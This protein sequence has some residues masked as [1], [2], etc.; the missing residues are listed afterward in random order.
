MGRAEG[1]GDGDGGGGASDDALAATLASD[2]AVPGAAALATTIASDDAAVETPASGLAATVAASASSAPV[3]P[4][5]EV[6]PMAPG[7]YLRTEADAEI[8]RGAIGRV[9]RYLDVHLGRE[10]AI[11]E[12]LGDEERVGGSRPSAASRSAAVRFLREARVTGQLEHPAI[13][14]VYELGQRA[15]GT[16]YYVMRE[17]RGRTLGAALR[18]ARDLAERVR[19]LDA[20]LAACQGVA[21]A[22]SRGVGPPRSEAGQR[23]ARR[24]RRDRRPRLGPREGPRAG[25]PDGFDTSNG[26][27]TGSAA[28]SSVGPS[29]ARSWARPPT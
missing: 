29:T 13:V 26:R 6:T 17:V 28:P 7:R 27:S 3:T 12:L 15:D 1:S 18:G 24:V 10:V 11:K 16:L 8:G 5:V 14:P 9:V 25:R 20:F 21:Y 22:H 4:A 19:H 2:D 23:H